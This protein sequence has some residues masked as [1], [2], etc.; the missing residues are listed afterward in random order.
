MKMIRSFFALTVILAVSM[1]WLGCNPEKFTSFTMGPFKTSV[2]I[3]GNTLVGTIVD[4]L[5]F[6]PEVP[7]NA[8]QTFN[9]HSTNSTLID[10]IV[11]SD[12]TITVTNP[13]GGNMNFLKDVYILISAEGLPEKEIAYAKEIPD[14]T[15]VLNLTET[16]ENIKAYLT[17]AKFKL[18]P[19]VLLDGVP[20][21]DTQLEI[22][23]SYSVKAGLLTK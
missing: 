18:K 15:T 10:E 14:G 1:G 6:S 11:L 5:P 16:N 3:P 17:S 7:T 20:L 21:Q 13:S 8:S 9:G 4:T 2:T 23:T 22:S 12:M 19:K